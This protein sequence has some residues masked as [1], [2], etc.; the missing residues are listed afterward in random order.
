MEGSRVNERTFKLT[1][2]LA[3][4]HASSPVVALSERA[5]GRSYT[6]DTEA[7]KVFMVDGPAPATPPPVPPPAEMPSSKVAVMKIRGPLLQRASVNVCGGYVDG[8]DAITARF[9]GALM[10][11]SVGA[12]VMVIDS[13]GGDCAGLFEA[14]AR[15]Q[16][17]QAMTKKPV[18][19]Y[20]DEQCASAAYAIA[21]LAT[22]G[23]F[24]PRS[25]DV[26]SVGAIAI[27]CDV[28][29]AVAKEGLA[30][31]IFRSGPRKAEGLPIEA[32]SDVAAAAIQQRVDDMAQQFFEVVSVARGIPVDQLAALGGACFSS[33]DAFAAKLTN[34]TASLETVF[35]MAGA[36]MPSA[37][38]ASMT[39]AEQQK[40]KDL[41]TENA[42]LKERL[43]KTEE[44][45]AKAEEDAKSKTD[46]EGG[47][48]PEETPDD[49]NGDPDDPDD[50]PDSS[51]SKKAT[52]AAA[53]PKASKKT[54]A[55]ATE[56][57]RLKA[58]IGALAA[59]D[60]AIGLTPALRNTALKLAKNAPDTVAGFL[61]E[62]GNRSDL[63]KEHSA[64]SASGL[65]MV[66]LTA[67]EISVAK[68]MGITQEA[69]AASKAAPS[70]EKGSGQ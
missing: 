53:T 5:F 39:D 38:G 60:S 22:E 31:Q 34:G 67:E 47:D 56:N 35:T 7:P 44:D 30:Y 51:K 46:G 50:A 48:S 15:M 45:M 14:V 19:V 57:A 63:G 54:N 58:E 28:T 68:Q 43:R 55:L 69:L 4:Q 12:M 10:D 2:E 29:G 6:L 21:C 40:Q 3:L 25:G 11:P 20:A 26:G 27:R 24:A 65:V 59:I 9:S 33:K 1:P 41:E 37:P 70:A 62:C 16:A 17:V 42:T 64:K 61:A 52:T 36:S 8:Y 66:V 32:L 23:I 13:P 49:E 18:I